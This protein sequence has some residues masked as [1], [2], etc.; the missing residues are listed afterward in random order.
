MVKPANE[1]VPKENDK[2][3]KNWVQATKLT[4]LS[5]DQV[6]QWNTNALNLYR[7]ITNN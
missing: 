4:G 5:P 6:A 7:E 1:Y 3:S 2:Y